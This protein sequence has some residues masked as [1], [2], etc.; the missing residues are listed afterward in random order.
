MKMKRNAVRILVCA[1]LAGQVAATAV[2]QEPAPRSLE[3]QFTEPQLL[4]AAAPGRP[5]FS[6]P[7]YRPDAERPLGIR[8]WFLGKEIRQQALYKRGPSTWYRWVE[9]RPILGYLAGATAIVVP[10][11][12][13]HESRN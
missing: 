2:G 8:P 7:H 4:P 3:G 12:V 11:V 6:P 5:M 10:I 9:D 1:V 13:V